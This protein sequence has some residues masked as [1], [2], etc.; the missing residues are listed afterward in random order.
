VDWER[1]NLGL[2]REMPLRRIQETPCWERVS[3]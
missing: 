3:K 1:M 2:A